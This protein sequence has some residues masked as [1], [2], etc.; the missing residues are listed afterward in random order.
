MKYNHAEFNLTHQR[1]EITDEER[2]LI[3]EAV[4]AG[5]VRKIP[6][7]ASAFEEEYVWKG[8][9]NDPSYVGTLVSKN[10]LT[11]KERNRRR[12][13]A[14][15]RLEKHRAKFRKT[16]RQIADAARISARREQVLELILAGRNQAEIAREVGFCA[17]TIRQDRAWLRATGKLVDGRRIG[18]RREAELEGHE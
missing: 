1:S 13:E 11:L 14:A 17:R 15:I 8:R 3:D 2:R 10:P 6:T 12:R 18:K 9:V 4:S 5:M 7:G 16:D